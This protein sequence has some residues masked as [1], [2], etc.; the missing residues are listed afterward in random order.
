MA[1]PSEL[2]SRQTPAV[3]LDRDGVINE[4]VNY[5]RHAD[6]FRLLPRSARAIREL[7]GAGF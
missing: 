2:Q 7:R 3:F 4:E 6:D 1:S 5:L